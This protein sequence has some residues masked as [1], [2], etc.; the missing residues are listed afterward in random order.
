MSTSS[1]TTT[2]KPALPQDSPQPTN[3]P[4]TLLNTPLAQTYTHIHPILL[5]SIYTARFSATVA[6]PVSSL[7][8]LAVV[9]AVLQSVYA[10]TCLPPTS[11][12]SATKNAE[13]ASSASNGSGGK[14]TKKPARTA[15]RKGSLG[16]RIWPATLSLLLTPPLAL[17]PLTAL[18]ILLGAPLTTHFPH[19]LL[20]S[21]HLAL[22]S[23]FPVLYTHG[24]SA[25]TWRGVLGLMRPVDE[26]V[27]GAL[28]ALLGAWLGCVPV[29]LDWDRDW[30][31]YP[32]TLVTGAYVGYVVGK[33]A[34]GTVMRG[35][36]VSFD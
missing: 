16:A 30:Q 27:G 11:E 3:T 12:G 36:V 14:W 26:V 19:T 4:I 29:P 18:A 34:G 8:Q 7:S 35:W 10:V 15:T 5:L 1:T 22:L 21:L 28:G 25:R 2:T 33:V 23:A 20:L 24:V 6:D 31:A 17:P 9:T 13:G 32:V